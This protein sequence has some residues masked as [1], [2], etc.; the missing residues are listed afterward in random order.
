MVSSAAKPGRASRFMTARLQLGTRTPPAVQRLQDFVAAAVD[1]RTL[2]G[3]GGSR[4]RQNLASPNRQILSRR[5]T[6]APPT[7]SC[8]TEP[9]RRLTPA[10]GRDLAKIRDATALGLDLL[11]LTFE[12][13][14]GRPSPPFATLFANAAS[15]IPAAI[16]ATQRI[17]AA[18]FERRLRDWRVARATASKAGPAMATDNNPAIRR[19]DGRVGARGSATTSLRDQWR[20][21]PAAHKESARAALNRR[22]IRRGRRSTKNGR[23]SARRCTAIGPGSRWLFLCSFHAQFATASVTVSRRTAAKSRCPTAA[24][25]GPLGRCHYRT[26]AHGGRA[27]GADVSAI[28]RA[29]DA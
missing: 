16:E 11:S 3:F 6:V 12:S 20:A 7:P 26:Q 4:R 17:A 10:Q 15:T 14:T 1:R 27:S 22:V 28:P 5:R 24:T 29:K 18:A 2:T 25:E 9:R 21:G 8:L 23:T 19:A 13:V